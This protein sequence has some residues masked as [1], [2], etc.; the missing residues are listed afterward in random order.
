MADSPISSLPAVGNLA[1]GQP[2]IQTADLFALEQ[3]STAKKL[4]GEQI[5]KFVDRNVQSYDGQIVASDAAGGA[6]YNSSTQKLTLVLPHGPGIKEVVAPSNPGQPGATDTYTLIGEDVRTTNG[7]TPGGTLGTF[8]VYNGRNGEGLVNSVMGVSPPS[9][10]TDIAKATLMNLIYPIGSIY[11]TED[12]TFDPN[13]AFGREWTQIKD[14]FLLAA[15]DLTAESKTY[16]VG[17]EDGYE[18]QT[19]DFSNGVAHIGFADGSPGNQNIFISRRNV[20]EDPTQD[21]E[22]VK[23]AAANSAAVTWGNPPIAQADATE[24]SGTQQLSNM[25]PYHVVCVW[26]RTALAT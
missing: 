18:T 17:D 25:P 3:N 12:A 11:M 5:T 21:Y 8:R 13:E 6:T 16:T 1:N 4:T 19:V 20:A 22:P 24:L 15:S 2:D 10:S 23:F 9:G 14:R 26:K 7:L